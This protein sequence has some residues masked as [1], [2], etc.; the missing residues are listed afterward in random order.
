MDD[1]LSVG[2]TPSQSVKKTKM[3]DAFSEFGQVM[4]FVFDYG[5]EWRFLV[6]FTGCGEKEPRKRYPRT[7]NAEGKAP[8]QYPDWDEEELEDGKPFGVNPRTGEIIRFTKN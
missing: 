1:D 5:D 2:S 8:L 4:L 7:T 6:E 3:A